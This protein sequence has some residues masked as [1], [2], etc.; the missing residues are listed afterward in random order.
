MVADLLAEAL[1]RASDSG[2]S[3]RVGTVLSAS[4]TEILVTV[5]GGV[6]PA[7]GRLASYTPIL[8]GDVVLLLVDDSSVII[9][10]KIVRA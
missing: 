1:S 8:P 2:L 9:A 6:V 10:G 7:T 3:R 5:G 4:A